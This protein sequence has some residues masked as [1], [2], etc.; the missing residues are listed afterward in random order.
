MNARRLWFAAG[1]GK[2]SQPA[3]VP[4]T[5]A[6]PSAGAEM[7]RTAI[8]TLLPLTPIQVLG[9]WPEADTVSV[10]GLVSSVQPAPPEAPPSALA[11]A[12]LESNRAR[13]VESVSA[14]AGRQLVGGARRGPTRSTTRYACPRR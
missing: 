4:I 5:V 10:T 8:V 3:M 6:R 14:I 2:S 12:A 9:A 11:A 7:A 1:A 13:P